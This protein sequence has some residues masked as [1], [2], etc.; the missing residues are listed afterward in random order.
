MACQSISAY[1]ECS[2][3]I[4]YSILLCPVRATTR[5]GYMISCH[6]IGLRKT[7][8]LLKPQKGLMPRE[9][10]AM[11]RRKPLQSYSWYDGIF[12]NYRSLDFK[13]LRKIPSKS[14]FFF[15]FFTGITWHTEARELLALITN[16]VYDFFARCRPPDLLN[17]GEPRKVNAFYVIA[18]IYTLTKRNCGLDLPDFTRAVAEM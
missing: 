3:S 9:M 16:F 10:A 15:L 12:P 17:S 14:R 8:T 4:F 7:K 1:S 2:S 13:N 18:C 5:T 11:S 6:L